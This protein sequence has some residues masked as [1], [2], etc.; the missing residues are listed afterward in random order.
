MS[1]FIINKEGDFKNSTISSI[2]VGINNII[3]DND[4]NFDLKKDNISNTRPMLSEGRKVK[5]RPMSSKK[6][7]VNTFSSMAN[8]KK[9]MNTSSSDES[10]DGSSVASSNESS[11]GSS[12]GSDDILSNNTHS[13]SNSNL[14]S[15]NKYVDDD[16]EEDN[17]GEEYTDDDYS[18][19]ESNK[20]KKSG[21]KDVTSSTYEGSEEDDDESEEE[22]PKKQK[23]YEEIQ[24]E[25]Q[26]LL[27]NLERL[28]KQGY[29]PS[30]KYSMASSYEDML[31]EHDRLKKQRDVEKSIKFSRKVLM[32]VVSGAEFLNS[33]FDYFDIK[34]N[35][36][37]ENVMENVS[38]YDEV[39]EE[40]HEKYSDSVKM[41]PEIK[42][43][44]L[45]SSSAFMFHLTN[46]L[47]KSS[48]S[49]VNDIIK[50]N[51][52]IMRNIQEAAARKMNN[53]INKEFGEGDVLGNIM[54]NGINM[55]MNPQ[56]PP[57]QRPG[58]QRPVT[59]AKMN[60][61]IGIDDL[62]DELNNDTRDDVSVSSNGSGTIKTFSKRTKNGLRKGIQL[63]I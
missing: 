28:Q 61:P 1:N 4:N 10:S 30:K 24:S 55:R 11:N 45:V 39:F 8:N 41:A 26:K 16:E 9:N 13:T 17:D 5:I 63:D 7:P 19:I 27:F 51:P 2:P 44:G 38:D 33:K 47:F 22:P 14:I 15:K 23:T 31:F 58:P 46:S 50:E 21:R 53:T 6:V 62:L 54:K 12:G 32:A 35:G 52:D 29:P 20:Y 48:K 60:G 3:L 56:Q 40:L 37:S 43:L 25:K 18:S 34:L 49:D 57:Q 42:L 36:W 59:Q